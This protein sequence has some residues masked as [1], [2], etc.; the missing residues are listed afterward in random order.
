MELKQKEKKRTNKPT[1]E[2]INKI[3]LVTQ[4]GINIRDNRDQVYYNIIDESL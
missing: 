1:G 4:L 3:G 2:K